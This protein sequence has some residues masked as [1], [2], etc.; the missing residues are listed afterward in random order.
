[1]TVVGV[2]G[3]GQL[4]R[5]LALAG[6]PLGLRFVFFDEARDT[7]SGRLAEQR[8]ARWDDAAALEAFA[9]EADLVTYEFEN[10]PLATAERIASRVPVFPPPRALATAGDRLAEKT[11]FRSLEIGTAP[12]AEVA[13]RED[14]GRAVESIGLPAVLKTRTQG[15]DGK[16]QRV[17]RQPA[18]LAPAF[19]ALG[20]RPLLLEGYV[21]FARELSILSV[22]GAT[23]DTAFWPLVQNV[24]RDGI[25][26]LSTAPAADVTPA[27][28]DDAAGIAGKVL[29]ALDYVGVLAI[30]LFQHDG[31]LLANEMAPR[32]H[33]SGHWT[34]EGAR[35]S[36]FENHLRAGLGLPLGATDAIGVSAMVNLIAQVPDPSALLEIPGAHLHLYGKTARPGRK[37]GHVTLVEADRAALEAGLA[38][39]A[40]IVDEP[41]LAR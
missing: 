5:M 28:F 35:T 33:N 7:P 20:G 1:M 17:L 4:G 41:A 10:V 29:E 14:L 38:R 25:L 13:T 6:Y 2:L 40:T 18:D 12:F 26:R 9:A 31:R 37:L 16:G 30:E 3:A 19:A 36:Q 23:G 8:T 32:V 24:H 34:I 21:P 39:L 27:L 11:L 15:Y 22:R